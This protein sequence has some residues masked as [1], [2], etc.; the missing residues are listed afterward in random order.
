MNDWNGRFEE[1]ISNY[2]ST[3]I[4]C[5]Y[6][7]LLYQVIVMILT[8]VFPQIAN[9]INFSVVELFGKELTIGTVLA[10]INLITQ[11][12][13]PFTYVSDILLALS[14]AFSSSERFEKN[15]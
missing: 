7:I 3:E 4:K 9:I 14:Q 12:A 10:M 15:I 2:R 11:L 8:N 5:L 13:N 1:K 6:Y